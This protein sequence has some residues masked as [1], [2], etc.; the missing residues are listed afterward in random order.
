MTRE[1]LAVILS[2]PD[3]FGEIMTQQTMRVMVAAYNRAIEDAIKAANG[4]A[5][6]C[7]E[8]INKLKIK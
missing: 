8:E 7:L 4:V 3:S 6:Y 5:D 1:E 2:T